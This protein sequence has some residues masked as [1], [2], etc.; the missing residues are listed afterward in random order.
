VRVSEWEEHSALS[1]QQSAKSK[2]LQIAQI[3]TDSQM[4]Q[5]DQF[6]IHRM[7]IREIR[8]VTGLG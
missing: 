7:L 4:I 2:P 3:F 6:E 5:Q 1:I 8:G